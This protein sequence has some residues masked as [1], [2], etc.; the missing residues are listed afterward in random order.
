MRAFG[1]AGR[2]LPDWRLQAKLLRL[3]GPF[4]VSQGLESGAFQSLTLFCGWLGATAL[5]AYQIALNLTALVF[6]ATVGLATATA[7]RVGSGIGAGMPARALAAAWLGV[8]VTLA[9]MLTLAPLIGLGAD[10]IARLY[11]TDPAVLALASQTLWLVALVIVADG[12]QGVL[13]G[14]LRGAADL[15]PPM[16]IHVT[17][18]WLVLVPAAWLLAFPLGRG[19]CAGLL[20]GVLIGL[21]VATLLL[22]WRLARLPQQPAGARLSGRPGLGGGPACAP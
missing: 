20:G 10:A 22:G 5:A 12:A 21:L 4:A 15:W 18:F 1:S 19:V 7:I 8:G 9:V 17:S 3:G 14:A 13:T 6:M 16:A 2:F 11:T